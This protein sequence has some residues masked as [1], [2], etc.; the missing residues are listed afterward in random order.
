MDLLDRNKGRE[1][2]PAFEET[3]VDVGFGLWVLNRIEH[4]SAANSGYIDVG[5]VQHIENHEDTV[6]I[7]VPVPQDATV[8]QLEFELFLV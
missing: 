3:G 6:L 5:F 8:Y 4:L 1:P 2:F 7:P